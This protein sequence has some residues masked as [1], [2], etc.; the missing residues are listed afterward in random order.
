MGFLKNLFD[1]AGS[2]TGRAI[3]NKLFPR[4]TD[5]VR[6][7]D[8]DGNSSEAIRAQSAAEQKR[9]SAQ[10]LADKMRFVMDLDFD[11]SDID[12]N[13]NVLAQLETIMESLPRRFDRSYEEQRLYKAALAKM[14]AGIALCRAKDPDNVALAYFVD[15]Y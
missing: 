12:H 9:I 8:L 11:A 3:G 4:S 10:L 7:G 5:Y 14:K 6:L 13:L 2:K 15:K 1:E